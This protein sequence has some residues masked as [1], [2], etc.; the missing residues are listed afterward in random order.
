MVILNLIL[1]YFKFRKHKLRILNSVYEIVAF[2]APICVV[3]WLYNL[4]YKRVSV[5]FCINYTRDSD[6]Y[7]DFEKTLHIVAHNAT[8]FSKRY[9]F[10]CARRGFEYPL[11]LRLREVYDPTMKYHI[12]SFED[13]LGR[14]YDLSI[15]FHNDTY[16]W[17]HGWKPVVFGKI[18]I[19][20][21]CE[22]IV[23]KAR[24]ARYTL[25]EWYQAGGE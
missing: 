18:E 11:L 12:F 3:V 24:R 19:D 8:D 1:L 10:L 2:Y 23:S 22:T 15:G 4:L 9:M 5:T 25:A 16:N 13:D 7:R 17:K 21:D 14:C 6:E 20:E